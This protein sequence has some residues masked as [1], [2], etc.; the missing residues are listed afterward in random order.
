MMSL[1]SLELVG[2]RGFAVQQRLSFAIPNGDPGSGLTTLVGPNNG[3]KSTIVEAL[4]ALTTSHMEPQSFTEGRRNKRAGDRVAIRVEDTSGEVGGLQTVVSGGSETEW[5]QFSLSRQM[6]VLQSRRYFN[7]F[8]SKSTVTRDSY[9]LHHSSQLGRGASLD[10]FAYRLFQVQQNRAAFDAVLGEVLKPVPRWTIDQ[11]DAGQ[12][13]LKLETNG[14]YHS[15]EGMGEG[16]V[17]LLF[18]IDALYDSTPGDVIVVDEPELSLHPSLQRRLFMLLSKYA[19]D[20]QI[21]IATHSP[22]FV[23]F[24]AL[25]NGAKVARLHLEDGGS[26]ISTLSASTV[27]RLKGFLSDHNNPHVLG[28]DAR[29]AFFLEDGII[30]VEGQEDYVFY[31]QIAD[32]LGIE[33]EGNFFGWGVGGADKMG[34]VATLLSELGFKKVVGLL[35]GN[36]ASLLPTLKGEFPQHQFH[37][38]PADDI[39]T[40]PEAKS[41]PAIF[42]ILDESGNIR[43]E[44][45]EPMREL[46]ARVNQAL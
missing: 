2:L 34:T 33:I 41:R 12:Y 35:D 8:F 39:R 16:L 5:S 10:Q 27:E 6:F 24:E 4:R 45:E 7:P 20:R 15:S 36:K 28:L 25:L 13:Y 14:Q 32:Q 31:K 18:I 42:G 43:S 44:H 3:G 30:L 38:I 17:S 22:Y 21:V 23:D 46:L 19:A 9:I 26:T 11:S 29:E 37:T 40:K 1:Q